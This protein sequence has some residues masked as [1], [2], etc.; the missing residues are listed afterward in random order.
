MKA[1]GARTPEALG[2]ALEDALASGEPRVIE[3]FVDPTH[4][5][6]TVFD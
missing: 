6:D 2:D 3:A 5:D 4:Y 1:L